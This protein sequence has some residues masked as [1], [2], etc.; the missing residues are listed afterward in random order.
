MAHTS[1]DV[2]VYIPSQT[3]F[4]MVDVGQSAGPVATALA[5]R[6]IC[7]RTGWGMP[8]HLRVSTGTMA[9]MQLFITAL[10]DILGPSG[11]PLGHPPAVTALFGNFPNPVISD[12]QIRYSV[13]NPVR[14]D[15]RIYDV[16][17]RLITTLLERAESPGFHDIR[18]DRL[19]SGGGRMPA[20][21]YFY[22]L[23]AGEVCETRRMILL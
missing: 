2:V 23:T 8:Q 6:G 3:N 1:G 5:A 16:H 12:T 7:V 19:D 20:G 9:D 4:F 11:L 10:R 18:W 22:R 13:A 21:C 14:V 17:G 15:L